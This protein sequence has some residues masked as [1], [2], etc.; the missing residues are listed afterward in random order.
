M[1]Q[2]DMLRDGE[3]KAMG[4]PMSSEPIRAAREELTK[5]RVLVDSGKRCP[6]ILDV[7]PKFTEKQRKAL[8]ESPD[9]NR[10]EILA[11]I[12]ALACARLFDTGPWL[13]D[14]EAAGLL[15]RRIWQMDLSEPVP[16]KANSWRSTALRKELDVDLLMVI[17]GTIGRMGRNP[18]TEHE[19]I[20]DLEAQHI[21]DM[22]AAGGDPEKHSDAAIER[23]LQLDQ[24]LPG[25]AAL[26]FG[27]PN[28][29]ASILETLELIMS[30]RPASFSRNNIAVSA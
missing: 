19:F 7:N 3:L 29:I 20:D 1:T 28:E 13:T 14:R 30:F 4:L 25:P 6:Q 18:C 15:H 12:E 5:R 9:T 2:Q 8:V 24:L 21:E 16:G 17:L 11:E 27:E 10:A 23:Q 22:L 26:L